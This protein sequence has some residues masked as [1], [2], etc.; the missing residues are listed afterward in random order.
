METNVTS[1]G[2]ALQ[3]RL[4]VPDID[5]LSHV[6]I[7]ATSA[8]QTG[9]CIFAMSYVAVIRGSERSLPRWNV[10]QSEVQCRR[11]DVTQT[12]IKHSRHSHI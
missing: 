8:A 11:S 9:S 10:P 5:Q 12:G 7:D 6:L 4:V 1:V 3:A 2:Q